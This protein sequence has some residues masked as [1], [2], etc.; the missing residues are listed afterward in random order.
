MDCSMPGSRASP[1]KK[2]G[3]GCHFLL[4]G[5]LP[6]PGIKPV[7]PALAGRFFTT[8]P[9]GSPRPQPGMGQSRWEGG[10]KALRPPGTHRGGGRDRWDL[11]IKVSC[12]CPLDETVTPAESGPFPPPHP[13]W[14]F[15]VLTPGC[16]TPDSLFTLLQPEPHPD[17]TLA[18]KETEILP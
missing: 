15:W 12:W 7:S 18:C 4:Q 3:V 8:E 1:S 16:T 9:P 13:Q 14:P 2:T 10:S 17:Q 6:D 11:S 5:V